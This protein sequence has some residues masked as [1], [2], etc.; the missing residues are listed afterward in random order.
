MA[1]PFAPYHRKHAAVIVGPS[2]Y[3]RNFP[4]QWV[5]R[6]HWYVEVES[7]RCLDTPSLAEAIRFAELVAS[8]KG[9]RVR[10]D[11][12]DAY[13]AEAPPE[14][15][16]VCEAPAEPDAMSPAPARPTAPF[17]HPC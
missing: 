8:E 15:P 6:V 17:R 2:W 11:W 12:E 4:A 5:G 1:E 16:S 7:R 9:T 13:F 10:F 3:T 14:K